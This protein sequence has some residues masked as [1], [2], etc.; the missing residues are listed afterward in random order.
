MPSRKRRAQARGIT[1]LT[2]L[3]AIL[4]FLSIRY[5]PPLQPPPCPTLPPPPPGSEYVPAYHGPYGRDVDTSRG[6]W[7]APTYQYS[8]TGEPTGLVFYGYATTETAPI[9]SC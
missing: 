9:H 5:L 6:L 2:A 8:T 4:I 7:Y 3:A 1:L